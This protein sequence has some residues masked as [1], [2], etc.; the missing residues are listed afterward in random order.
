MHHHARARVVADVRHTAGWLARAARIP[1]ADRVRVE[2]RYT[3]RTRRT[4]DADNLVA[5]LKPLVDGLVDAGVV[6][7]DDDEHVERLMP[8]IAAPNRNA[9]PLVLVVDLAP[10][11]LR[12]HA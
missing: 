7:D 4:R 1:R 5:L 12:Q 3:P 11:S 2:L 8:V 6:A 10:H 9:V